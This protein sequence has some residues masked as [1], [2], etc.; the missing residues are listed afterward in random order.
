MMTVPAVP[1][2]RKKAVRPHSDVED[3][4]F[5]ATELDGQDASHT[6]SDCP[7]FARHYGRARLGETGEGTEGRSGIGQSHRK[8]TGNQGPPGWRQRSGCSRGHG[9][10]ARCR[11]SSQRRIG[12]RLFSANSKTRRGICCIGRPRMRTSRRDARDLSPRWE[13]RSEAETD[14]TAREADLKSSAGCSAIYV[15]SDR[16]WQAGDILKQLDLAATY[17]SIGEQ[18]PTWFYRG[19]LAAK[20]GAWMAANGGLMTAEDFAEYG[21]IERVPVRGIYRGHEIVSFPPPSSGGIHVI[22]ILQMLERFNLRELEPAVRAHI[23]AEAMKIAFADRAHWLGDPDFANV[24]RGLIRKDYAIELGKKISVDHMAA[25][26]KHGEPPDA[27][28]DV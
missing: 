27:A 18:G 28:S 9:P 16:P 7:A 6:L 2:A 11:R 20:I 26:D 24:P 25:V 22:Q 4:L 13:S 5:A 8:R 10:H 17:R 19:E 3:W 14:W 23:V 1:V 21:V 15:R 12:R